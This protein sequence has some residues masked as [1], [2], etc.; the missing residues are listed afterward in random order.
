M[1]LSPT[2]SSVPGMRVGAASSAG[3]ITT[4]VSSTD[5]TAASLDREHGRMRGES[6]PTTIACSTGDIKCASPPS[7]SQRTTPALQHSPVA[8]R[9]ASLRSPPREGGPPTTPRA[10]SAGQ[11]APDLGS[12]LSTWRRIVRSLTTG[13]GCGSSPAGAVLPVDVAS[14]AAESES[15]RNSK[16]RIGGLAQHD[17]RAA[18]PKTAEA[19]SG[20]ADHECVDALSLKSQRS[21]LSHPSR[22]VA[23]D[24]PTLVRPESI[25]WAEHRRRFSSR[26][27]SSSADTSPDP[28][29]STDNSIADL[30]IRTSIPFAPRS[31][32][33]RAS[34]QQSFASNGRRSLA[35]RESTS[36]SVSTS[37]QSP[38]AVTTHF[39]SSTRTT[40]SHSKRHEPAGRA[41]DMGSNFLS[42]SLSRDDLRNALEAFTSDAIA[43]QVELGYDPVA[44]VR[45]PTIVVSEDTHGRRTGISVGDGLMPLDSA[46]L[47][48]RQSEELS[49]LS[50]F[51]VIETRNYLVDK[52]A[53]SSSFNIGGAGIC[54][55]DG[56]ES[57][58]LSTATNNSDANSLLRRESTKRR[59]SLPAADVPV[60]HGPQ[61]VVSPPA[62]PKHAVGS[63]NSSHISIATQRSGLQSSQ[64]Y[65]PLSGSTVGRSPMGTRK[66]AMRS[67]NRSF[68]SAAGSTAAGLGSPSASSSVPHVRG[69]LKNGASSA[70]AI[71]ME[72]D[73][74][75][76]IDFGGQVRMNA[77][78]ERKLARNDS[79]GFDNTRSSQASMS[80]GISSYESHDSMAHSVSHAWSSPNESR[81]SV[82][83]E[84]PPE[85]VAQLLESELPEMERRLMQRM[86]PAIYLAGEYIIRKH[87][88][89][90]QMYFLSRGQVEV[91]SGDGKVQ[92]SV[93]NRGSFF[94]ELG[95]LF[96]IPRTASV[97]AIDNCVC[98]VLTRKDL[99]DVMK[100]F[101]AISE[102]FQQV[103]VARMEEV[104][105]KR[106]TA[107]RVKISTIATSMQ[108]VT[109]EEESYLSGAGRR[110]VAE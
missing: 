3:L 16:D 10:H 38:R 19:P 83:L 42:S 51:G 35:S 104:N 62:A 29:E 110:P 24:D 100:D 32:V 94:G 97:R 15:R 1:A 6:A 4:V 27:A 26:R 103:V 64:N 69:I 23:E 89:G 22:T 106:A 37:A 98:M 57:R 73:P 101:P 91:V 12:E 65:I 2:V 56:L 87:D 77:A 11:G 68:S 9:H 55:G 102:R 99:D 50:A 25:Q 107:K 93:I 82:A 45:Q 52:S 18:A 109:E 66:S 88:I 31:S 46:P 59:W 105:Q 40:S 49:T 71:P 44:A 43:K 70:A 96:D 92:Y 36:S 60:V 85:A 86:R 74:S 84:R 13:C 81:G 39:S 63:R 53:A 80:P 28:A 41:L 76:V 75:I 7:D 108:K 58:R 48:V 61:S 20:G 8:A 14:A 47:T 67:S 79:S 54:I 95:V 33:G 5:A 90:K 34:R 72:I 17:D 21:Q 30:A 78:L